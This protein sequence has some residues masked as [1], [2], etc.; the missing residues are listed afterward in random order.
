MRITDAKAFGLLIA[1]RRAELGWTQADLAGAADRSRAWVSHIEAGRS[2]PTLSTVVALLGALDLDL[3]ARLRSH[4][5][6]LS[7]RGLLDTL[8][9]RTGSGLATTAADGGSLGGSRDVD[10]ELDDDELDDDELD[11]DDELGGV[12]DEDGDWRELLGQRSGRTSR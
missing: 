11:D 2:D 4:D 3:S 1:G 10:D 9:A 6:H 5:E 8:L 7:G 12:D